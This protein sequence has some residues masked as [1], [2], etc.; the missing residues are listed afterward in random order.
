MSQDNGGN[1]TSLIL[2]TALWNV[3]QTARRLALSEDITRR[4]WSNTSK[5]LAA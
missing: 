5:Q 4:I 1:G 3:Q 2:Q